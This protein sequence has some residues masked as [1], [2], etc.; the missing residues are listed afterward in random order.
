MFFIFICSLNVCELIQIAV[1]TAV[2]FFGQRQNF[3]LK[4]FSKYYFN[5]KNSYKIFQSI[6]ISHD[7]HQ[8]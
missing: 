3:E 1:D 8:K 2:M 4:I 7:G 6:I 5:Y